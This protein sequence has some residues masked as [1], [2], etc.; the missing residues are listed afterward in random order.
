[1]LATYAINAG[2]LDHIMVMPATVNVIASGSQQ[3]TAIGYDQYDNE[4]SIT[5]SWSTDVGTIDANGLFT[6]QSTAGA[7]GYVK[8]T[9]DAIEGQAVVNIVEGYVLGDAD[10][11]GS[12]TSL[13]VTKVERI[14]MG[15]DDPAPGADA[16]AD[17]S[18]NT[19]DI[20]KIEL[21][22]MGG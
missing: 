21:I 6:A 19:L 4:V 15:L 17:G 20:T 13:D 10:G 3:F 1:M 22:I 16:N 9:V 12:V 14:I 2:P 5:P 7:S 11:D 18:I 8:A